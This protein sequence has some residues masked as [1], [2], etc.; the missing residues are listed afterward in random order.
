M[1][2]PRPMPQTD[3][4]PLP[5][6]DAHTAPYWEGI[7]RGE[8][9]LQRCRVCGVSSH[10]AADRCRAC[11]SSLLEWVAVEPR[12]QLFSWAVE[13][14]AIIPGIGAP[15]V[16]AQVT[17]YG[18]EEGG[19]RLSCTLLTADPSTLELGMPVRLVAVAPPGT[20]VPLAFF[21]PA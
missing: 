3:S 2:S 9:L 8:L 18:C 14:R 11:D 21:E 16:I 10:P 12:G 7:A 4:S 17:P 1:T 15:C 6:P 13:Q 19:V 20:D 5:R